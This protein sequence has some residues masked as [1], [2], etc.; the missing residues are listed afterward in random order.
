[1]TAGKGG[2]VG[3]KRLFIREVPIIRAGSVHVSMVALLSTGEDKFYPFGSV[4]PRD[5]MGIIST[6]FY[7]IGADRGYV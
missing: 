1:M 7:Q 4:S 3:I 5:T 2:I 6:C